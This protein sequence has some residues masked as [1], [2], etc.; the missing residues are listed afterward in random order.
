MNKMA[1]LIVMA[2]MAG[3][4]GWAGEIEKAGPLRVVTICME[5]ASAFR[6]DRGFDIQLFPLAQAMASKLFATAGVRVNWHGLRGCPAT[7]IFIR[8]STDPKNRQSPG[9]FAYALPYDSVHIM[10]FCDRVQKAI[11]PDG[12]PYVMAYVLVHEVAH[13]LQGVVRHSNTGIMKA[14]W[15]SQD[16][17]QMYSKPLPFTAEDI[18]L[19][20]SGLDARNRRLA[21]P[22]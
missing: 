9:A 7:A 15:T 5:R 17:A 3:T 8:V 22:R 6:L 20:Q 13:V 12:V 1:G 19:I 18:D 4:H 16:Y 10:I 21:A 2:T 11:E 14:K